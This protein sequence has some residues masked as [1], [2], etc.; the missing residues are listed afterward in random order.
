[1]FSWEEAP[2][3][4]G[5]FLLAYMHNGNASF[6]QGGS[7]EFARA[8]EKRFLALG[9]EICYEAQVEKILVDKDKAVGVRLYNDEIQRGDVVISA[10]DGYGTIFHMLG[11][12]FTDRRIRSMYDGHL[13]L[14]SMMQVSLGL[15]YDLSDTPYRVTHLLD[16]PV[17]V[18][19]EPRYEIGVKHFGFDPSLVPVVPHHKPVAG[20]PKIG[21][22][23]VEV[24]VR[25]DYAYWQR[26]YG[27]RIYDEEQRQVSQILRNTLEKWHPGINAGIEVVD[28]AT[29]ISYERYTG[30]WKGS[31][32]GWLLC[33]ETM[34]M[35]INGVPKTLPGLGNFYMAGQW[36]EPGGTVS[37]AAAS[38]RNVI[39]ML[40][41]ADG[42]E[43][44]AEMP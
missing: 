15:K 19:G 42:K 38:G 31:T 1:M 4:M 9:G 17:L 33:K 20:L 8:I 22:T 34:P 21:K 5:M 39:Q 30:N 16:E 14:H 10:C 24:I 25:S 3:M 41:A 29:P 2:V 40:C 36:V 11:G 13:P 32:C 28:E 18:A 43:F 35:M 23:V 27:R 37:M 26:I 7:L 12:E 44:R 6:P